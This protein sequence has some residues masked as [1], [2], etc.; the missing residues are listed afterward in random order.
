M[1]VPW[2]WNN[3]RLART[4]RCDGVEAII[5]APHISC[6]ALLD[7]ARPSV[8]WECL[9]GFRH[10]EWMWVFSLLVVPFLVSVGFL[11]SL[12]FRLL[13]QLKAGLLDYGHKAGRSQVSLS[14]ITSP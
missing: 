4:S 13:S 3:A 11:V 14:V 8:R 9:G 1:E 12:Y 2:R 7:V 6:D 10:T 5:Q